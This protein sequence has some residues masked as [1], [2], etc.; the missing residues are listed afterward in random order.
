MRL[1]T[2]ALATAATLLTLSASPALA[3]EGSAIIEHCTKGQSLSGFSENGYRE[4]LKQMPTVGLEYSP[5]EEQIRR[6]ELAAAGGGGAGVGA[7]AGATPGGPLPLTPSEQ[8]EVLSAQHHA[9]AP[10]LL[11]KT[12]VEPGVV[13]ADI[14]SAASALPPSLLAVLALL[15]AGCLLF[16]TAKG[17]ERVRARRHR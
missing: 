3:S 2:T 5:C 11:G 7:A 17:I 15:L 13:H 4:A 10:V 16:S 12:P 9:P 8:H 6:A 1:R 14:A